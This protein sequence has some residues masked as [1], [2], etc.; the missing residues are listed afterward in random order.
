MLRAIF[1]RQNLGSL[2]I[3]AAGI[4][5]CQ[6]SPSTKT[7]TFREGNAKSG[8]PGKLLACLRYLKVFHSGRANA[9]KVFSGPVFLDRME[10]MMRLRWAGEKMSTGGVTAR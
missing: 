2:R 4:F 1:W 5:P 3:L 9:N 10:A 8:V 6:K 7:A